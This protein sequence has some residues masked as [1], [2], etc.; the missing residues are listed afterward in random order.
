M[1][2]FGKTSATFCSHME[3]FRIGFGSIKELPFAL[4]TSKVV[5]I[6]NL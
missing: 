2:F 3:I 5:I 4:A 1:T 6:V